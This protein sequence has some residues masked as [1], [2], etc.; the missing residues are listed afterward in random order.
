M[1]VPFF[2]FLLLWEE[3]ECLILSRVVRAGGSG[4]GGLVDCVEWWYGYLVLI[5]QML[6]LHTC[7]TNIEPISLARGG[8][9]AGRHI[10]RRYKVVVNENTRSQP[11]M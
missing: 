8:R 2:F 1:G 9:Q 10:V 3:R 11:S 5:V 4:G 7:S 6:S